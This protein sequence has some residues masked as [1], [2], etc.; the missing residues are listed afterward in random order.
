VYGHAP[1]TVL[2]RD[3]LFRGAAEGIEVL[4]NANRSETDGLQHEQELCLRL[5]AGDSTRPEI[6]VSPDGLREFA[7][8]DDVSVE[9][10][11]TRL[12]DPE[13]LAE[14]LSLVRREIEHT[15]ADDEVNTLRLDWYVEGIA[16]PHLRHA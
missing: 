8:H 11:T 15:V 5:S 6:N 4:S 13:H 12:E 14:R 9:E 3:S 7:G 16:W 10:V 2:A 1:D